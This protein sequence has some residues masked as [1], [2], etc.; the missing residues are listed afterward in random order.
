MPRIRTPVWMFI[1]IAALAILPVDGQATTG[2]TDGRLEAITSPLPQVIELETSGQ[3]NLSAFQLVNP[4]R[5]VLDLGQATTP[6]S[7]TLQVDR[8]LADGPIESAR[9]SQ[10][11][12]GNNVTRIVIDLTAPQPLQVF[13]STRPDGPRLF[14]L[15]PAG[16]ALETDSRWRAVPLLIGTDPG[17]WSEPT[18]D[19]STPAAPRRPLVVATE[20]LGWDSPATPEGTLPAPRRPIVQTTS[21]PPA[22]TATEQPSVAETAPATQATTHS[23]ANEEESDSTELPISE[24]Q[25]SAPE[26]QALE[27][28]SSTAPSRPADS[29]PTLEPPE[30]VAISTAEEVNGDDRAETLFAEPTPEEEDSRP[31]EVESA[32]VT[33]AAPQGIWLVRTDG[34]RIDLDKPWRIEGRR[35]IYTTKSGVL[36]SIRLS[37]VDLEASSNGGQ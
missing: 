24:S 11:S 19:A 7:G 20:P 5:F 10:F 9:W 1:L 4:P 22:D 23:A 15:A 31:P 26:N 3:V 28:S 37:N 29:T 33:D 18:Q 27:V 13:E 34:A 6:A 21:Q 8:G 25:H 36:S 30:T 2:E 35:V 16:S 17:D 12:G 32:P 14:R